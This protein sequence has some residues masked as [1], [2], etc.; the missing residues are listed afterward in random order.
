MHNI[1]STVCNL[2]GFNALNALFAIGADSM[3]EIT[4]RLKIMGRCS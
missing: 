2:R 3:G 1:T 4:P